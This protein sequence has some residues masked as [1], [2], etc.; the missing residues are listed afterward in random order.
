[1]AEDQS[2]GYTFSPVS[3]STLI[4]TW[5][6]LCMQLSLSL[7][8]HGQN[9]DRNNIA[10]LVQLISESYGPDQHLI[11]GIEYFNLHTHTSGHKFLD[12]DKFYEGRVVIDKRVYRHVMLKYDIFNQNLLLLAE[13]PKGGHKQVILNNLRIDE[14]ELNGRIFR[15]HTFH[16]TGTLFYQVIGSDEIACFYHFTKQEIP[17][18]IDQH[19]LSEFTDVQKKSYIY[20]QSELHAFNRNRSFIRIFPEHQTQIK[21]FLRQNKFQVRNMTDPQMYWLIHH[22]FSLT[23]TSIEE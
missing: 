9:A 20:W 4:H 22:C 6:I 12:E 5:L 2:A 17:R 3:I 1:M 8:L 10:E 14:F 18:A 13:Q 16:G 23:R 11:N 21:A 7:N 19:T 15:K